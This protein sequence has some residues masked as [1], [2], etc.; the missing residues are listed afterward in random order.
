MSVR[1]A[2]WLL[3]VGVACDDA[4]FPSTTDSGTT[5]TASGWCAIPPW[6]DASCVSCHSPGGGVQGDLDLATDP[7]AA[8]VDVPSAAYP[9]Q[10][11][12]VPGDAAGS[13][14]VAK[15]AG[16]QAAGE[17]S[18]M[19]VG[20][21]WSQER[22]DL[23]SQWIDA[24]ASE[25]CDGTPTTPPP[26][27]DRTNEDCGPPGTCGAEE[28]PAMLPGA[29][30]LAC[31]AVGHSGEGPDF[32]VAGTIYVDL[33]G[34]AVLGQATVHLVGADGGTLD[35]TSNPSGNFYSSRAL[36]VPYA[37]SIEIGGETVAMTDHQTT[38]ACNSCHSCDGAAGGKLHGP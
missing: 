35:I 33:P 4:T 1:I 37:A 25:A 19:P 5:P 38:G 2:P 17:G 36:A 7:Y 23:V 27:C 15:L 28:S 6:F 11:L 8:L 13:F 9:G 16:T 30:C 29:D 22:I 21:G 18:P 3:L 31:H 26:E 14:L 32:T 10:V 12:V 20:G 24:G 34:T